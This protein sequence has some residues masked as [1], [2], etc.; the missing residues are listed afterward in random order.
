M[1]NHKKKYS[2]ET[3]P[4]F[5]STSSS[6]KSYKLKTIKILFFDNFLKYQKT[7]CVEPNL[8]LS[9][10]VPLTF[11]TCVFS[12]Y[13]YL[14]IYTISIFYI[15]L[16]IYLSEKFPNSFGAYY[17]KFLERNS[18]PDVFKKYCGNP[19][20]TLKSMIQNPEF[21]K[22]IAKNGASKVIAATGLGLATEHTI[23]KAKIGQ[24][25]EYKLD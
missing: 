10:L 22:I 16:T 6:E 24:I 12:S 19:F 9:H 25:Y 4:R 20:G 7:I 3:K 5:F 8:P 13:Y 23:H 15:I 11:L 2:L 21:V 17:I 18:S 14:T 1:L